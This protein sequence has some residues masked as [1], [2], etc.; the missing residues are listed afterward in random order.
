MRRACREK[1]A[2]SLY[3]LAVGLAGI[4]GE[5]EMVMRKR[6]ERMIIHMT[7][8]SVTGFMAE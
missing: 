8:T 6:T 3:A 2:F 1:W 4:I 5:L 7:F